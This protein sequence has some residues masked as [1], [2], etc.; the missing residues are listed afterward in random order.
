MR[1][2]EA[3]GLCY[4]RIVGIPDVAGGPGI[5]EMA[6]HTLPDNQPMVQLARRLGFDIEFNEDEEVYDLTLMLN[7]PR[8][9]W[10]MDRL[11]DVLP[12][13]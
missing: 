12:P 9:E 2:P 7:K 6:G 3:F 13:I 4:N 10:Q 11:G 5:L 1:F 8:E